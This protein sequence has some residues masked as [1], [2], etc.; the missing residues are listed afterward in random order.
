MKLPLLVALVLVTA[1]T[2]CSR[3]PLPFRDRVVAADAEFD[4][5]RF[6]SSISSQRADRRDFVVA[7]RRA[8][9]NVGAALE[10]GRYKAVTYCL[11]RFGAS[12]IDWDVGPDQE[13][14]QVILT[15]GGNLAMSGRCT[16][17]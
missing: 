1:T 9:R 16:A 11:K 2:A 6:R 17:R 5:Q 7:V 4:G 15:E 13:V 14:E 3:I 12:D 10:A 8:D